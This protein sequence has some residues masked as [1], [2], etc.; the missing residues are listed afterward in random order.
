MK[1][2]IIAIILV[3]VFGV[4]LYAEG[5]MQSRDRIHSV[6]KVVDNIR[7]QEEK[8]ISI[9][10]SFRS[11]FTD[12]KVS[13]QVRTMYAGYQQNESTE[14]NTYATA[15]GGILKYELAALK[16]F[17]AGVAVYISQDLGFATG[18]GIH[19]NSELSS[20]QGSYVDLSE[21]YVNYK[22]EDFNFRGGRQ[23]LDTPLADSDDIRMIQNTFEAYVASYNYKGIE[24]MGG[25]IQ[26]WQGVDAG[27]DGWVSVATKG[28][29]FAGLSYSD[30]VEFNLWFYNITDFTNALYVDIGLEQELSEDLL[31]HLG[32][33]YLSE[34]QLATSGVAADIYGGLVELVFHDVGLN[35]SFNHSLKK[36][37][38]QSFSGT[39]GGS[40]YTSMDTMI[41]DTIASDREVIAY[42]AGLSYS[43]DNFGFLYAHGDF[44]GN[45]NSAG[46]KEHIVEHD[47]GFSYDVNDEFLVSAIYAISEDEEYAQATLYD[48]ERLQLMVNYNF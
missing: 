2:K 17:N 47:I 13:G 45:A 21:V 16:G 9:V 1:K 38:K 18:E 10:D 39:G 4:T 48:F 29:N 8:D 11:M 20:S 37:F 26:S 23:V 6:R 24:F 32:A 14:P 7:K 15:A 30:R 25:T 41:I 5:E 27:L 28:T 44:V 33:Q 19:H 3:S 42:V 43:I 22:Y 12:G 34:T 31:L 40:M 35:L 36:E 46:A